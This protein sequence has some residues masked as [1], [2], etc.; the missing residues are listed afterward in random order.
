MTIQAFSNILRS[1]ISAEFIPA[2]PNPDTVTG[3]D[4]NALKAILRGKARPEFP[5]DQKGALDL[6]SRSE[7]S[8]EAARILGATL[9]DSNVPVELR[10]AAANLMRR[11]PVKSTEALLIPALKFDDDRLRRAVLRSLGEVGGSAAQKALSDQPQT[12]EL[13]Y[14]QLLISLR[15]GTHTGN[16]S[17]TLG[18]G[19]VQVKANPVTEDDA[20]LILEGIGGRVAD[21]PL[22]S[23]SAVGFECRNARHTVLLTKQ[24]DF[25]RSGIIGAVLRDEEDVTVPELRYIVLYSLAKDSPEIALITPAGRVDYAGV[26]K[27]SR[28][29]MTF[30]LRDIGVTTTRLIANAVVT[31]K[32]FELTLEIMG[33]GDRAT[34][35]AR[36]PISILTESRAQTR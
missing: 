15:C 14:A 21:V 12:P 17:A 26:G 18:T 9:G 27:A 16:L 31:D 32:T 11:M 3:V 10:M 33:S 8:P 7:S 5:V 28:M 34:R 23:R 6:L 4:L 22:T 29:G 13:E 19:V 36:A 25:K 30:Q 2:H 24:V 1:L 20:R 35:R